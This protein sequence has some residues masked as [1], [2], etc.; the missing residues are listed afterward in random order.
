MDNEDY[1]RKRKILQ[2]KAAVGDAMSTAGTLGVIG[3]LFPTRASIPLGVG[4]LGLGLIGSTKANLARQ[5]M[6]RYD[7]QRLEDRLARMEMRK[8]AFDMSMMQ[9]PEYSDRHM[10]MKSLKAIENMAAELQEEVACGCEMPSWVEY[11]IY[12]SKDSLMSVLGHTYSKD[13]KG[14]AREVIIKK[15]M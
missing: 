3:S 4:G 14:N 8:S 9:S 7:R 10:L 2:R 12:R 13:R 5:K 11:K 1:A 15:L 6:D